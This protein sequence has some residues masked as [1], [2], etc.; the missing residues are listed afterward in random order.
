[1]VDVPAVAPSMARGYLALALDFAF[2]PLVQIVSI[3]S[4]FEGA[5][6]FT[7]INR[8]TDSAGLSF[9]AIQWAQKPGRLNEL[10]RAC[11]AAENDVFVQIFGVG[12]A[13]LAAALVEHTALP[14]CGVD[15]QG[16]T[17]DPR[18]D[19]TSETWVSRFLAAGRHRVLQS[20]QVNAALDAFQK[21]LARLRTFAPQIQSQRGVAFMLDLA[22]QH[23]DGGAQRIFQTVQS[24]GLSEPE[25][26]EA[27][28]QESVARVRRQFGDGPITDSTRNRREAFRTTP[29]LSDEPF[30]EP[31]AGAAG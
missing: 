1:M 3:T 22:N 16:Q 8:N 5:G 18:F 25:L 7:A 20:V 4:Q 23:G 14:G 19:L 17:T 31:A 6:R 28:E 13:A 11:Q 9:G 30:A 10:L 15:S 2:T 27:V 26:L 24:P 12:D 21:S 29:L